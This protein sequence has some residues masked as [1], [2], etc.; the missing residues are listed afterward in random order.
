MNID[1]AM[2]KADAKAAIRESKTSPYLTALIYSLVVYV[3]GVLQSN[4]TA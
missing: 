2:L 1:R 3:L 4:I